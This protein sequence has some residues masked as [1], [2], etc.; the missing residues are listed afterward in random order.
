MDYYIGAIELFPYTFAPSG[1]MLCAGQSIRIAQ[2]QPLFSLI[3]FQFGK[4]GETSFK[5]PDLRGASPNGKM[6][7]YICTV[8]LYPVSE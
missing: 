5:L 1:W 7:Y 3:S 2:N 8:G 6:A 4:D